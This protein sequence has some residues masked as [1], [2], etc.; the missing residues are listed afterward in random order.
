MLPDRERAL[1]GPAVQIP[2]AGPGADVRKICARYGDM[3]VNGHVNNVRYI[4]WAMDP[5]GPEVL[6]SRRIGR[7]DV[8][9][10]S[11]AV[12]GDAVTVAVESV[13]GDCV[14]GA[15]ESAGGDDE[16]IAPEPRPGDTVDVAAEHMPGSDLLF[17]HTIRH[18]D[19]RREL[20]RLRS[21]WR[22]M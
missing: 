19:D 8:Q 12:F 5:V 4:E 9:F 1:T 22:K 10:K 6:E 15:T 17:A 18:A 3:D 11:E 13:G 20:T 2:E 7:L 14:D 21:V 16:G